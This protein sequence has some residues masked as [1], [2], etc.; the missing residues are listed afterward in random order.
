VISLC[1]VVLQRVLQLVCLRFRSTASKEF[2]IVVLRHE[3]AVLRRQVRQPPF[4]SA[5]RLFLA[6]AS[7]MLPKGTCSSF[8]VTPATL[9]RWHRRLVANHC[10]YTRRAHRPPISRDVRALIVRLAR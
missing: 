1:Y 2:E 8:L 3:L 4:R 6:A 7:R 9:L 5:D 10:T